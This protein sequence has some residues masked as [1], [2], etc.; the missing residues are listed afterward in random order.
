MID[1][2]IIQGAVTPGR[3][4]SSSQEPAH[5]SPFKH[6][7]LEI[8]AACDCDCFGCDRFSDV[9]PGPNMTVAQVELFVRES[10]EL[11]WQWE[12]IRVLGGEPTLHPQ[13]REIIELVCRYRRVHPKCF[14]QVLSNGRGK[15]E[16]HRDWLLDR[17]VDPHVEGPKTPGVTP[18][19]FT[20]TRIVPVDRDPSVGTLL[21]CGIF[22][23]RGC[24][25]GLTPH[26]YFL[27]GAGAAIARVAGLDV[28]VMKLRDVTTEAMLKQ[29]EVLCRLC[30]HWTAPGSSERP[31]KVSETGQV[32]G[33][34]WADRI[35]AYKLRRPIMTS[36]GSN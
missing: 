26:G 14:V 34:F 29:A 27:D 31:P 28:G 36:Y 8:N 25:L 7:E 13:F 16:H 24:G 22:G 6:V 23:P 2:P 5:G 12:R 10:L 33:Q 4:D 30:G 11:G 18:D 17:G 3:D 19:W 20:N 1:L 15:L 21:P 32:T 9:L 35:M